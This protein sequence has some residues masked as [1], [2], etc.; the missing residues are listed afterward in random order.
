MKKIITALLSLPLFVGSAS[1]VCPICT[2]AVGLGLEGA[3]RSGVDDL[4][5]GLWAGGFIMVLIFWTVKILVK[6]KVENWIWYAIAP[7]AWFGVLG[8]MYMLPSM[9]YGETTFLG[10]DRFLA[11]SIM[12]IVIFYVFEKWNAKLRRQN[13][14]KSYFPFQKVV[15]PF[16]SLLVTSLIMAAFIYL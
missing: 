4:I 3:R 11:G 5:T 2:A 14:G 9:S 13:G 12:G 16:G 7:L 6:K 10:V 15:L 8:A 1:A